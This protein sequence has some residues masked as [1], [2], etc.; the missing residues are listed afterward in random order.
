M[1]TQNY[2]DQI[3][4]I[5]GEQRAAAYKEGFQDGIKFVSE[6]S[7]S[8]IAAVEKAKD[9]VL[10]QAA[11]IYGVGKEYKVASDCLNA[12]IIDLK[13]AAHLIEPKSLSDYWAE[14]DEEYL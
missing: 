2:M 11:N 14:G 3:K 1:T 4:F 10:S 8:L 6:P 7:D 12:V 13:T 9:F 5:V